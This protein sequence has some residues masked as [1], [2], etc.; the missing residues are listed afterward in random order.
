MADNPFALTGRVAVI[1]GGCGTLGGA[2]ASGLAAA[3]A[4]VAI[5]SQRFAVVSA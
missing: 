3:D 1:T 5:P 4:A 2:R